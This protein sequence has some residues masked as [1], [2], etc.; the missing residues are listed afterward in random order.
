MFILD[1]IVLAP[2]KGL[3]WIAREID[4]A[5]QAE[6]EQESE[7]LT[8]ELTRLYMLLETGRL[9]EEEFE[10]REA[11]LLERMDALAARGGETERAD[12]PVA[13]DATEPATTVAATDEGGDAPT[14]PAA[15]PSPAAA[16]PSPSGAA[17]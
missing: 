11:E 17:T 10:V 4:K 8:R 14:L 15:A 2:I 6:L 1:D 7:D 9:S 13:S 5:A 12:G 16:T 3:Q